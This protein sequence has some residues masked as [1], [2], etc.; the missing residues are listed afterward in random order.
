MELNLIIILDN[1]SKILR[2]L[3]IDNVWH[4]IVCT[5]STYHYT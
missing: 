2:Q 3:I 4:I 1:N 5:L